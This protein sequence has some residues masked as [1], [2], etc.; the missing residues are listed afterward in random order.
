MKRKKHNTLMFIPLALY[1]TLPTLILF[2]VILEQEE[3]RNSEVT[4]NAVRGK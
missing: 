1:L 2:C 3:N 4:T